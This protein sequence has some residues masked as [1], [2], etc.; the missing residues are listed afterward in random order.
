MEGWE[1]GVR[2]PAWSAGVC[3][4]RAYEWPMNRALS[5]PETEPMVLDSPAHQNH[6]RTF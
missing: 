6:N 2:C 4:V 1:L 5:I 3:E